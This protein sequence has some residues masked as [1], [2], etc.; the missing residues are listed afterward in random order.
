MIGA[1]VLEVAGDCLEFVDNGISASANFETLIELPVTLSLDG[2]DDS[3]SMEVRF[4]RTISIDLTTKEAQRLAG[5]LIEW[6]E[7]RGVGIEVGS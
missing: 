2:K 3:E 5:H 4:E 7:D 1:E 6:L